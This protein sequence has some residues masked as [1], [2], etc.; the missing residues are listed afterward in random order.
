MSKLL[1]QLRCLPQFNSFENEVR[2][3][4]T[5]E[6]HYVKEFAPEA[7]G[8]YDEK[9]DDGKQVCRPYHL[10]YS[11]IQ[12]D[13]VEGL[14]GDNSYLFDEFVHED[15]LRSDVTELVRALINEILDN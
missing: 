11:Q 1:E 13:A 14:L 15:K 4:L 7:E 8:Y 12:D 2:K 3:Q 9:D 5:L 6:N 10:G